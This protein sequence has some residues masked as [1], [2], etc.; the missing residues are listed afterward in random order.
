MQLHTN[1]WLIELISWIMQR[2]NYTFITCSPE[3]VSGQLPIQ[4]DIVC[5][6]V[7]NFRV[8]TFTVTNYVRS[9]A[10]CKKIP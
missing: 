4:F 8:I 2:A 3:F 6:R 9:S 5:V 1:A 10:C 7:W